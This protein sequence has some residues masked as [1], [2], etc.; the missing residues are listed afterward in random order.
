VPSGT[1]ASCT[2]THAGGYCA[3]PRIRPI[4]DAES[5]DFAT[6]PAAACGSAGQPRQCLRPRP[7]PSSLLAQEEG[8][9]TQGR[10]SCHRPVGTVEAC[11]QTA[12]GM[13][14]PHCG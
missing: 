3:W 13:S 14:L 8:S 9:P 6:N 1:P 2:S 12:P 7:R 4:P 11:E 5:S 10:H